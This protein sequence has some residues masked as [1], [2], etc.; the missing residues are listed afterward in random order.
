MAMNKDW[1]ID[2]ESFNILFLP[3]VQEELPP[4]MLPYVEDILRQIGEMQKKEDSDESDIRFS[5]VGPDAASECCEAPRRKEISRR[6]EPSR[7]KK[8]SGAGQ[9]SFWDTLFEDNDTV[10]KEESAAKEEAPDARTQAIIDAWENIE[11][12]FG[13]TI[14]DL[15]VILRCRVK[16]SRL[17]ITTS[18]KLFLTD[19]D[20]KEVKLDD[21]TKAL[22]YFYLRH[23]EGATLKELY[24]HEEEILKYY[25][26]ITGRDDL[27]GI[28]KSVK[29]LLDPYGNGRN[30]C[31]SRIKKALRDAVGDPV[32]G[33]YYVD[34]KYGEARKV[35][36][37]RDLVIWEH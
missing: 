34:G 4:D 24:E 23:P 13:I 32:A 27:N 33:F 20:N 31:M 19:F 35:R 6:K 5:V 12:K 25:S 14:D 11:R 2:L 30:V 22:Y 9:P 10:A 1:Q 8:E 18:N 29:D 26:G 21:L 17:T 15:Y 28:R 16:L 3:E 37:D 36:I 7:R